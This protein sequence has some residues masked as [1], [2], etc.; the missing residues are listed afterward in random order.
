[1][2]RRRIQ[3]TAREV[4]R[5]KGYAKTSIEQVARRASLS[6]GA[7][8]LYFKSKEELYVSLLEET[9]EG[10]EQDLARLHEGGD[11]GAAWHYL[12][13]WAQGE[14]EGP[15]M[16]RL[17]SQQGIRGQL[18][19][20]V[21]ESLR[22]GLDAIRGHLLAI[23]RQGM[24]SGRYRAIDNPDTVVDILWSLYLGTLQSVDMRRN[25]GA[26]ELD[27]AQ[28]AKD[29]FEVVD[30]VLRTRPSQVAEAA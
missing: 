13:H 11:L 16:L 1:M 2:R 18:S 19:D 22:A 24:E 8:Y 26:E 4:F 14:I 27:M 25:L 30:R 9:F 17:V 29:A 28:S 15:R 23:L 5:E 10:F 3:Q 12:V 6:V 20:E 7:I 21:V